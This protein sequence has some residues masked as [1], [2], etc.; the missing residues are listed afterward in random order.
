MSLTTSS[1]ELYNITTV[2]NEYIVG[3]FMF[4]L[5]EWIF[6]PRNCILVISTLIVNA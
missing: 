3:N 4:K 5:M 1:L 2:I 6:N